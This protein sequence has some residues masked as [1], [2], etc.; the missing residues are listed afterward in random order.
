MVLRLWR[1]GGAVSEIRAAWWS[2][3]VTIANVCMICSYSERA[4]ELPS[5]GS[6]HA[7]PASELTVRHRQ[8]YEDA[9][10]VRLGLCF[11]FTRGR[12][13]K[14]TSFDPINRSVKP[15]GPATWSLVTVARKSDA[16]RVWQLEASPTMITHSPRENRSG[17]TGSQ[18]P[19]DYSSLIGSRAA[20]AICRG[21][22]K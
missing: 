9:S 6:L 22:E 4:R 7:Q 17:M 13:I 12:T 18:Q 19:Q 2:T 14:S 8:R 1:S 11:V 3:S 20:K 21:R 5:C 16:H 15:N 10:A